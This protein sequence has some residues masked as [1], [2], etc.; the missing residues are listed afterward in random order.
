MAVTATGAMPLH[1]DGRGPDR[2]G[3]CVTCLRATLGHPAHIDKN[4]EVAVADRLMAPIVAADCIKIEKC[5]IVMKKYCTIC[6]A[7]CK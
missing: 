2:H 5:Y 3:L 7:V 6:F 1:H 4:I